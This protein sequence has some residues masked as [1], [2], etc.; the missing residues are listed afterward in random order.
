MVGKQGSLN[1]RGI[2]PWRN[3]YPTSDRRVT[4]SANLNFNESQTYTNFVTPSDIQFTSGHVKNHFFKDL[5]E[6]SEV[7]FELL[8]K[9]D[10]LF[11][12]TVYW[13]VTSYC[14]VTG[15]NV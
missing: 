4:Y 1:I 9:P 3:N 5:A 7:S 8:M 2:V 6:L 13:D 10:S 14:L 12:K 11:K 15:T